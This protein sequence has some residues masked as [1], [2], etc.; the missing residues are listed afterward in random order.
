MARAQPREMLARSVVR[1]FLEA[2]SRLG[3]ASAAWANTSGGAYHRI[4]RIATGTRLHDGQL[5]PRVVEVA[6]QARQTGIERL[7]ARDSVGNRNPSLGD[8]SR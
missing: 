8:E 1:S 6:L 7:E 2:A 3:H 4:G 5:T